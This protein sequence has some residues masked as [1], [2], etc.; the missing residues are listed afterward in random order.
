MSATLGVSLSPVTYRGQELEPVVSVK[1][2]ISLGYD[3]TRTLSIDVGGILFRQNNPNPLLEGSDIRFAPTFSIQFDGNLFNRIKNLGSDGSLI[4]SKEQTKSQSFTFI[5][6]KLMNIVAFHGIS[7]LTATKKES[8]SLTVLVV[9]QVN[10]G[11]TFTLSL[12]IGGESSFFQL[13]NSQTSNIWSDQFDSEGFMRT[14]LCNLN[15]TIDSNAADNLSTILKAYTIKSSPSGTITNSNV[16]EI[17]LHVINPGTEAE[18][19]PDT[20]DNQPT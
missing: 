17:A 13:P 2:L 18:E 10:E 4:D 20:D 12:E 15:V 8:V 9:P 16:V 19:D 6:P 5:I 7:E 14:K 3:I 1:P 11:E